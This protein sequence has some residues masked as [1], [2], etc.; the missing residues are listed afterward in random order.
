MAKLLQTK[1]IPVNPDSPLPSLM[2]ALIDALRDE[3]NQYGEM[4]V[5]LDCQQTHVMARSPEEVMNSVASINQHMG[6]IQSAR[7]LREERQHDVARALE[8]SEQTAFADLIPL[9]PESHRSAIQALVR[10]NNALL[11]RVQQRARQ[12]HILLMRS[13]ELM[14]R[15]LSHLMPAPAPITYNETGRLEPAG[16]LA[17][18]LYE[19]VG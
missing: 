15:F 17:K 13:L 1:R 4:L 3:L 10:E 14:Q 11:Q 18:Q 9:L 7:A 5:L 16:A 2:A 6:L 12:N 8:Q 19:A